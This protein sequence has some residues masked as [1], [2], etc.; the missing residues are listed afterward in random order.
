MFQ[1]TYG[2]DSMS[3][4]TRGTLL[5]GQLQEGLRHEIMRAPAV[6]G[7]QTYPELYLVVWNEEKRLVALQKRK[8]YQ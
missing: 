6:S 3:A 4:E 2:H 5:H 8:Q 1:I 7:S